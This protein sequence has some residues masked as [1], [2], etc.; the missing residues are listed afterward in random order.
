MRLPTLAV[1]IPTFNRGQLLIE[2][3]DSIVAQS[4]DVEIV[5]SDNASTDDT[6]QM[7][8]A[9][10]PHFSRF[11]IHRWDENVGADRNYLKVIDLASSDY[12]W[13]MGSDDTCLPNSIARIT[14]ALAHDTSLAGLSLRQRLFSPQMDQPRDV[15]ELAPGLHADR[16]FCSA[17][18]AFKVLGAHF[19]YLSAQV[20]NRRLWNQAVQ[21]GRVSS[22][23][24]AYSHVFVITRM[25]QIHPRWL[26]LHDPGVGWRSANDSF[27]SRGYY[28]RLKLDV[29]GYHEIAA[30]LFGRNSPETATIDRRICGDHCY[31]QVRYAAF[32]PVERGYHHQARKLLFRYYWK[33]PEFYRKVLPWLFAPRTLLQ[34]TK[35]LYRRFVKKPAGPSNPKFT[36]ES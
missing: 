11:V 20:V 15:K 7:V 26:Y 34:L 12:C 36:D 1:C 19:G 3:L 2:T 17:S 14:S 16:L 25:L 9:Y 27:V 4:I 29:V 6:L 32:N 22:F 28:H 23:H 8:E 24:N 13:L 10:R 18:E 31:S 30:E 33:Y 35:S 21:D 5:I